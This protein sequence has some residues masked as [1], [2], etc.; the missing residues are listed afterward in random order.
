[1]SSPVD[2]KVVK[3]EVL[4]KSATDPI[5]LYLRGLQDFTLEISPEII[6]H[7]KKH[8]TVTIDCPQTQAYFLVGFAHSATNFEGSYRFDIDI[9]TRSIVVPGFNTNPLY[10]RNK[11]TLH[12]IK[13][14]EASAYFE[15][16]GNKNLDPWNVKIYFAKRKETFIVCNTFLNA[17]VKNKTRVAQQINFGKFLV[18]RRNPI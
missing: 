4:S 3:R 2:M 10:G 1:M 13:N 12:I 15:S 6:A 17:V 5:M 11:E 8:V 16:T 18:F 9:L 14:E 7:N